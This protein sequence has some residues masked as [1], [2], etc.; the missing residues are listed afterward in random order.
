MDNARRKFILMQDSLRTDEVLLYLGRH[1]ELDF[2][3][4]IIEGHGNK[5]LYAGLGTEMKLLGLAERCG[6][7]RNMELYFVT[8]YFLKIDRNL[9]ETAQIQNKG[10]RELAQR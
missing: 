8:P 10:F 3:L 4:M 1:E 9:P 5:L 6:R 2:H 7:L